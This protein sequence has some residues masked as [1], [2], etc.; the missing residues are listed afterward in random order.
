[1]QS[2]VP[3]V[4]QPLAGAPLLAHVLELAA[5]LEPASIHV[6]LRAW[7][8]AG[9]SEISAI[10]RL[11]W[12]HQAEQLGTAHALTQAMPG[13]EDGQRVLVLYGDV[14]LLR[15]GD[16]ARTA[17]R[18]AGRRH[19]CCSRRDSP[20][21]TGYGR[22]VRDARGAVRRIVEECDASA[23]ERRLREINTGVLVRRRDA[24]SSWLPQ[25]SSA[26]NAQGEY[27]LT[28][29]MAIAARAEAPHRRDRRVRRGRSAGY[30]RQAAA[31][32]RLRPMY[33]RRRA[34]ELMAQGVTLIDPARIDL[35]G[36][37]TV[38]RDVL[39]DVNV[40]LEGP[41]HARRRRAHRRRTAWSAM[42]RSGERTRLHL[43]LR[44]AGRRIGSD[45]QI[46]PFT[47]VR[48]ESA[49]RA[50][51]CIWA[52]SSRSRT[53]ASATAARPII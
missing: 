16:A 20:I 53:A 7:R 8:R 36:A 9:A 25:R 28:D 12:W 33:R 3:K 47:R 10:R 24:S 49:H 6:V 50:M 35:R 17:R 21:P 15:A 34:R 14:P 1:M 38:G 22:I 29:I 30:Q 13:I 2:S 27:Y 31:R 45:C 43:Q 5:A 32:R 39:L 44:G 11:R 4:L 48:P 18:R 37:I 42:P 26:R 19:R 41:V 23:R 40:V 52:I 46:G 51:A